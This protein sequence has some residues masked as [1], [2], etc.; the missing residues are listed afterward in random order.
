MSGL[1]GTGRQPLC[2]R[3]GPDAL[4]S[5]KR[6]LS[7]IAALLALVG[8]AAVAQTALPRAATEPSVPAGLYMERASDCM[9]CHTRQGGTPFA[10]GRAIGT[11]F[12]LYSTNITPDPDTGSGHGPT[13]S[14]MPRCMTASATTWATSIR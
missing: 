7:G 8:H 2:A 6:R 3:A 14:S 9:A 1:P 10:G 11:P 5:N 4:R 12:V 13:T